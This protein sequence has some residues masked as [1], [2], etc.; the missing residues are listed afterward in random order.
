M[1]RDSSDPT[2]SLSDV[3]DQEEKSLI[4]KLYGIAINDIAQLKN[5][6]WDVTKWVLAAN[7]A[8]FI[9][10]AI[11]EEELPTGMLCA[12]A[13][14]SFF[15]GMLAAATILKTQWSL[16]STRECLEGYRTRHGGAFNAAYG[17]REK[18]HTSFWYDG[19]VWVPMLGIALISSVVTIYAAWP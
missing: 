11:K 6:Q 17:G 7:V 5:R 15:L 16:K 4:E 13:T 2:Q 12:I 3:A 10:I 18:R 14:L 19:L 9:P 8:L 1:S